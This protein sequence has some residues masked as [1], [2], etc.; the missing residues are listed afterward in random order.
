L[1][2]GAE[3]GILNPGGFIMT[4]LPEVIHPEVQTPDQFPQADDAD[5]ADQAAEHTQFILAALAEAEAYAARP[6]AVWL[7]EEE[8]WSEDEVE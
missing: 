8:F 7:T 5:T 2:V 4:A 3:T 1:T 6:D